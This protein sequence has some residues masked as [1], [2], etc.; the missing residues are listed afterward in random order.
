MIDFLIN[1]RCFDQFIR[2]SYG[3]DLAVFKYDHP[4]GR[5]HRIDP[6]GND[7]YSRVV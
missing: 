2:S 6:L 4:V 3:V 5:L 1:G 7:K